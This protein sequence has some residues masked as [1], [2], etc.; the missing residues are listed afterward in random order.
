MHFQATL[1]VPSV[2]D[3]VTLDGKV[4]KSVMY[5]CIVCVWLI[6]LSRLTN[7]MNFCKL[8]YIKIEVCVFATESR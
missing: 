6:M 3:A 7:C 5:L 2:S 8:S 4:F 1:E